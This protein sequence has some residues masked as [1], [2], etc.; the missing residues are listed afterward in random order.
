VGRLPPWLLPLSR[1]YEVF[2][3]FDGSQDWEIRCKAC[4]LGT[5]VPIEQAIASRRW[6]WVRHLAHDLDRHR[7]WHHEA[8]F[9]RPERSGKEGPK[10]PG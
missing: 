5:R 6:R 8:E 9:C 7:L 1:Y 4:G 10:E 2:D 3:L